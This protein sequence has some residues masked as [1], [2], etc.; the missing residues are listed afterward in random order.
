M[1]PLP[2][3]AAASQEGMG[4]HFSAGWEVVRIADGIVARLDD[5]RGPM[6]VERL[7]DFGRTVSFRNQAV[8]GFVQQLGAQGRD[9]K[10]PGGDDR[11]LRKSLTPKRGGNLTLIPLP[12]GE[13]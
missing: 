13:G 1:N 10:P 4:R 6:D 3:L 2:C 5:D 11:D 8:A 7:A 12:M 9:G